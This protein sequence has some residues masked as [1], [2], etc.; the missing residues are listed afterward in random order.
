MRQLVVNTA[1][2]MAVI[3]ATL[4]VPAATQDWPAGWAFFLLMFGFAIAMILWLLRFY[5]ELLAERLTG[6]GRPA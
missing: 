1:V 5:P 6:I 2:M 3:A 4:F